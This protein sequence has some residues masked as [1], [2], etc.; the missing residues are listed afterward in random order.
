ML[1]MLDT[2]KYIDCFWFTDLNGSLKH[3]LQ[4][5]TRIILQDG[6]YQYVKD[7]HVNHGILGFTQNL[8]TYL[9]Y[10]SAPITGCQEM[11]QGV[12]KWPFNFSDLLQTLKHAMNPDFSITPAG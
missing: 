7:C 3:L 12:Q 8:N 4:Q 5:E 10:L 11:D 9:G 2:S 1:N 6:M